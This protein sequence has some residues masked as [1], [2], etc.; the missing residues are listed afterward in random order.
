M[1]WSECLKG[2]L[3]PFRFSGCLANTLNFPISSASSTSNSEPLKPARKSLF[4]GCPPCIPEVDVWMSM[5]LWHIISHQLSMGALAKLKNLVSN[6]HE[7]TPFRDYLGICLCSGFQS[8][9][10]DPLRFG[11]TDWLLFSEKS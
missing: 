2:V 8:E 3:L 6:T 9:H 10:Q 4:P 11:K 5:N 1:T 7:R